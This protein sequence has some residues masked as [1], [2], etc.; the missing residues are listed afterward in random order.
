MNRRR[1]LASLGGLSVAGCLR[2]ESG[3]TT[4]TDGGTRATATTTAAR[5]TTAVE[6]ATEEPATEEPTTE[7]STERDEPAYPTGLHADGVYAYLA[8]T[9]LNY[10]SKTS[11]EERWRRRNRTS[12][13]SQG[14]NARVADGTA[15]V[16]SPERDAESYR[17]ADGVHWRAPASDGTVYGRA[18]GTFDFQN[19]AHVS[20]LR[21]IMLAGSWNA[22]TTTDDG[23]RVE[24][25]GVD[26][27]TALENRFRYARI[28]S[29]S[30]TMQVTP[31]GVIA[32]LDVAVDVVD[33]EGQASE[34]AFGHRVLS[35]GAATAPEPSWHATAVE[36]APA[37]NVSATDDAR[38]VVLEHAGGSGLAAEDT[39]HLHPTDG[40]GG[41]AH[42]QL[43]DRVASGETVYAWV[44]DGTNDL[45]FRR[46]SRPPDANPRT[47]SGGQRVFV[48]HGGLEYFGVADVPLP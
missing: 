2:L 32:D 25:A 3:E 13:Y 21:A 42:G 15:L 1:L 11:F 47:I 48:D 4:A 9:H 36:R 41:A 28:E 33:D 20:E 35:V 27:A 8:D 29:L 24:A 18:R 14:V 7:E 39:V 12:G 34:V 17:T 37:V 31:D 38:Y 6:T 40:D 22:P 44:P 45:A 30:G 5:P 10:L 19:V 43:R 46:G 23:W 26:D 16:T